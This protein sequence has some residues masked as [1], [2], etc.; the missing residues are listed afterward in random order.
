[1]FDQDDDADKISFNVGGVKFETFATTLLN[2]ADTRLSWLA[3]NHLQDGK[4][5]RKEYFFDRHPGVFVHILNFYRTG[6]LHTP[7][8]VCGPLFSEELQFWGIDEKQM[9]PCCWGRFTKHREAEEV[10]STFEGPCFED[11]SRERKTSFLSLKTGYLNKKLSCIWKIMDDPFSSELAKKFS[12]LSCMMICVSIAAYCISTEA[13]FKQNKVI[14]KILDS[15]EYICLIFFTIELLLRV[16]VCPQ[17]KVFFKNYVSWLDFASIIPPYCSL[18]FPQFYPQL[19]ENLVIIRLL[20]VIK[21]FKLS[22]GLQVFMKTLKSS[23]HELTL[24]F[25]LLLIP[26]IIFSSLV[27]AVEIN[28]HGNSTKNQ[29]TSI[30]TAFWW[31]VITMTTIGYGDIVPV[32]WLGKIFGSICAVIGV[33]IVALPISIIGSN[34]SVYYAH[35]KARMN[36]P[37][38]NRRL[39]EGNLRGLLRQPLSLSSRDRDRRTIKRQGIDRLNNNAIR[40]KENNSS[41]QF[42]DMQMKRKFAFERI[43]SDHLGSTDTA[44]TLSL[45]SLT[46]QKPNSGQ[47]NVIC[48]KK[49]TFVKQISDSEL[50]EKNRTSTFESNVYQESCEKINEKTTTVLS[51]KLTEKKNSDTVKLDE[52]SDKSQPDQTRK[53]TM[54]GLSHADTSPPNSINKTF[55]NDEYF[56]DSLP[57]ICVSV[58]NPYHSNECN[59]CRELNFLKEDDN[60]KK[61]SASRCSQRSKSL[62][63]MNEP[64]Y[65]NQTDRIS[66]KNSP[67]QSSNSINNLETNKLC[68]PFHIAKTKP[69]LGVFDPT[70]IEE[71]EVFRRHSMLRIEDYYNFPCVKNRDIPIF[72]DFFTVNQ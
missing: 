45:Q 55:S 17:K 28:I 5:N 25:F 38:K 51:N 40:R 12:Y 58:E 7:T 42:I 9:E 19:I 31:C 11:L 1:M 32:T 47:K 4:T 50:V 63:S 30:P 37:Q 62:N 15:I 49:Y 70:D 65:D 13:I 24:L 48:D 27:Y 60:F 10:L 59:S 20:R 54:N 14:K 44:F 16:I 68:L 3:E 53:E 66:F 56:T 6:K 39:L 41:P 36:L 21:Y 43:T 61:L 33:L 35:V 26:V 22:Y 46:E 71:T 2:I 72:K 64:H 29:F 52:K 18:I 34:F 8:D 67:C 69:E 57:K 23:S